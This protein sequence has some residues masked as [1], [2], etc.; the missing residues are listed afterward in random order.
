MSGETREK[1]AGPVPVEPGADGPGAVALA[2]AGADR[3]GFLHRPLVIAPVTGT[4]GHVVIY[5]LPG[6]KPLAP[7]QIDA[8]CREVL[9]KDQWE[10]LVAAVKVAKRRRAFLAR[11]DGASREE[12]RA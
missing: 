7:V 2:L 3:Q 4:A 10:V 9:S 1:V 6:E 5:A 8:A 11:Q 12:D